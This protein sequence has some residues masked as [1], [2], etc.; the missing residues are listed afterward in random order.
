MTRLKIEWFDKPDESGRHAFV[1]D[2]TGDAWHAAQ[3]G[4]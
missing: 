4:A 1:R 2:A 3:K